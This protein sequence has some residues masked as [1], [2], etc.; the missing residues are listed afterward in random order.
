MFAYCTKLV[1]CPEINHITSIAFLSCLSMFV[2]CTSLTHPMTSLPS[3]TNYN[4]YQAMFMSCSNLIS[5]P[6]LPAIEIYGGS[7]AWMFS[8]CIKLTRVPDLPMEQFING[9]PAQG[10]FYNCSSLYVSDT[11]GADYRYIW[12]IPEFFNGSGYDGENPD[13][14]TNCLGTR[15]T[16]SPNFYNYRQYYYTQN[17][18][19]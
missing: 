10:M 7:Y 4:S 16:D 3:I 17:D 1:T 11:Y 13:M 8:Q 5:A 12:A 9:P 15:S 2:G 14:F 19:I 18:P 6:K